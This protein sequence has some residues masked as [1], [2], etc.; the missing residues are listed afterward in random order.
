MILRISLEYYTQPRETL[1]VNFGKVSY[2]MECVSPGRWSVDIDGLDF[3]RL[4]SFCFEV[5]K[6]G[7]PVRRDWGK[8]RLLVPSVSVPKVLDVR[9]K[10]QDRPAESPFW[11]SMFTD[12]VFRRPATRSARKPGFMT[13]A[14]NVTFIVPFPVVRQDECLAITGSGPFFN[15][16][17]KAMPLGDVR[18]PVWDLTL[19]VSRPFEYKFVIIDKK[20]KAVKA[21][22]KGD[23]HCLA[24][25]PP[26]DV[27]LIV[28]DIAPRFDVPRWRGTGTSV[29]VFSLRSEDSFGVGEFLDIKKLADWAA[30]TGQDVIQLLPVNDTSASGT[31]KDSYPYNAISSFALHPQYIN[32]PAAGVRIN[33]EY[34]ELRKELNS[35]E[36]LD[37]ERV[38]QEKRRLLKS[39]FREH[40]RK[41]A[42]MPEFRDFC[43]VNAAWLKPYAAWCMLR[44]EFGT[45]DFRKWGNYSTYGAR[46]I[47]N[48][49][50]KNVFDYEFYCFE[51]FVADSQLKEAAAYAHSRGV[52]LKG[53]IPIGVCMDSV[54][55][56]QHPSLFLQDSLT[57][58]PPD[59]FSKKGQN[60]GFPI[61]NWEKMAQDG[62]AWWKARLAKMQEYFDAFR[63]DHILGFFRIWDIP[64]SCGDALLGHFTPALPY[65]GKELAA[66]GFDVVRDRELFIEDPRRKGCYHPCICGQDSEGYKALSPEMRQAY[67]RLHEDFFYHRHE[68]FWKRS[69][70]EKL[71]ALVDSTHMLACGEDLGM[72]PGCVPEV[73]RSMNILSLEIQRMPKKFGEAFG[74]TSAYPYYS[75]CATGTHDTSTLRGWWE[76]NSR[77]A[78]SFWCDVLHHEGEAPVQCGPQLCREIVGQHLE[79]PSMLAILPLQDWLSTDAGLAY[80]GNPADE[81]I[82]DPSVPRHYWRWRMHITLE[83]LLSA[84]DFNSRLRTAIRESGRGI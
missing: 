58:A 6:D 26:R 64:A 16:W 27:R 40:G 73:M 82:N 66:M 13:G 68:D 25:V 80:A 34:K 48:Y 5:L 61:Y 49:C 42:E 67:D 53:D 57:G 47:D 81:R 56:W 24:Y 51:Q 11:S 44:D 79:S 50:R 22:E 9:A 43:E 23:N 35:L 83:D 45:P 10:W 32:L 37:Y 36:T 60:W 65:S 12:V 39:W 30:E 70:L 62:Y 15:D 77:V 74:D 2:P 31:W 41:I 75:V 19:N 38:N 17:K 21:W 55:V 52:A 3:G 84:S 14:G 4:H 46:K 72:V 63:I 28:S 76:E 29:P 69:A 54:D 59:S 78:E 7:V 20:T 18:F 1:A 33:K 8:H 71:P